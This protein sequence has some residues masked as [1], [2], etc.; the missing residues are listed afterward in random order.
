VVRSRWIVA[1]G[2]VLI[3]SC[4]TARV[5]PSSAYDARTI[6]EQE[7]VSSNAINAYEAIQRLRSDFLSYRGE[8][9]FYASRAKSMPIVYVDEQ[10]YG[11]ITTLENI[12]AG[13]VASIR[14]YRAWEATT[15]YGT[16]NTGGVI[17]VT[18]RR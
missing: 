6:T 8:T 4:T 2:P 1:V 15:K 11:E 9:S 17:A 5:V 7:I 13:Q 14:L 12:P 10:R 3:I 16:G 18:T